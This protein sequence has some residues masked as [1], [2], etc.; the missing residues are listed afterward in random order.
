MSVA[1]ID[2]PGG[3][4]GGRTASADFIVSGAP[5]AIVSIDYGPAHPH[6]VVW[7]AGA[8]QYGYRNS[9]RIVLG[10]DVTFS[11]VREGDWPQALIDIVVSEGNV[12][13]HLTHELGG[14]DQIDS[15]KLKWSEG[16]AAEGNLGEKIGEMETA[17]GAA[18]TAANAAQADATDALAD[19]DAA[20]TLAN[21]HAPRHVAGGADQITGANLELT[22]SPTNYSTAGNTLGQHRTG[23]DTAL[24]STSVS[25]ATALGVAEM[26]RLTLTA[27]KVANYSPAAKDLVP[28]DISAGGF[29]LTLPASPAANDRIGAVISGFANGNLLTISGN[30]KTIISPNATTATPTSITLWLDGE[31]AVLHYNATLN[32]WHIVAAGVP[33]SLMSPIATPN[34]FTPIAGYALDPDAPTTDAFGAKVLTVSGTP[35]TWQPAFSGMRPA[36]GNPGSGVNFTRSDADLRITGAFSLALTIASAGVATAFSLISCMGVSTTTEA[37]NALW[38]I[39]STGGPTRL[40]FG[41]EQGAGVDVTGPAVAYSNYTAVHIL[42]TRPSAGT[43]AKM[44]VGGK[45]ASSVT[46]LI[47]PTGGGSGTMRIYGAQHTNSSGATGNITGAIQNVIIWGSELTADQVAY[48]ARLQLGA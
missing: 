17:T 1:W 5:N 26:A 46:G 2:T 40:R 38:H 45:L 6:E 48:Y 25:A 29:T 36:A 23:I 8:F 37:D 30:G 13:H 31:H 4:L 43:S 20:L 14:I 22:A 28:C 16:D 3:N 32:A 47:A 44:Y 9:S 10:D 41:W 19:A 35:E 11:V 15:G 12:A 27:V 33:A 21:T 24:G 18:L 34:R 7:I 39:G 42:V